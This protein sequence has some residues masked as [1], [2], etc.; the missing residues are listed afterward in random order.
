MKAKPHRMPFT[1]L[2]LGFSGTTESAGI[3]GKFGE[4]SKLKLETLK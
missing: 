4:F 1:L 3:A 2:A